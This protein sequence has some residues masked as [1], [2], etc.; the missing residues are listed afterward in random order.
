MDY[1]N[2]DCLFNNSYLNEVTL[3]VSNLEDGDHKVAVVVRAAS[4]RR[5]TLGLQV[6]RSGTWD[7]QGSGGKAESSGRE[8]HYD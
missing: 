4:L 1:D 6:R 7:S 8:L 3:L 5:V 2:A